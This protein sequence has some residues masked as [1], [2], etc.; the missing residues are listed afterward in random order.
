MEA[1]ITDRMRRSEM[2]SE[3]AQLLEQLNQDERDGLV[4]YCTARTDLWSARR[5][6]PYSE[7]YETYAIFNRARDLQEIYVSATA[8][9]DQDVGGGRIGSLRTRSYR[10]ESGFT[11]SG[12][13]R[14]D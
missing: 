4:K 13:A 10:L 14:G 1:E 7:E 5:A 11:C 3:W 8:A 6:H 9:T 2:A 12:A